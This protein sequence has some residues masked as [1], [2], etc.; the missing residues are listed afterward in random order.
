MNDAFASKSFLSIG[1]C[2]VELSATAGGTWRRGFAGDTFN[3]AWYARRM[4]P[5]DWTVGYLTRVGCDPLSQ[6]MLAFLRDA[7]LDTRHVV[8][9]VD[10]T[11]GLY[12]IDLDTG[13][14]RSF[15]YWRGQSAARR[16]ASDL[17]RLA[18]AIDPADVIFLSGITLAILPPGEREVLIGRIAAA[19]AAGKLTAFDPNIRPHLWE[20]PA[21]LRHFVEAA[22]AASRIVLPSFDDEA[23]HF[24]DASPV[25]TALRYRGLG[26][27]EVTVKNGKGRIVLG[28]TK[29]IE[30]L[31]S[32]PVV[33]MVDATGAGDSF[34]AGYLCARILGRDQEAAAHSGH[35]TAS[36]VVGHRGAILPPEE[37]DRLPL[38]AW[39]MVAR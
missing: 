29:E 11:V 36:V 25:A 39:A 9:E 2:M 6:E 19:T 1:E 24:G 28:S 3:T 26:A 20:S 7:G 37:V 34:N 27:A 14:E 4:L 35:K 33:E 23:K 10:R 12:M 21:V 38:T 32:L 17:Q 8:Q 18:D 5:P 31:P 15:T 13:G 16:L 30:Q 22:A